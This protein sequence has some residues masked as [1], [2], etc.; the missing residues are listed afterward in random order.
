MRKHLQKTI[1]EARRITPLRTIA[2]FKTA[3][4]D[5]V[6][7]NPNKYFAQVFQAL[8]IEVNVEMGALKALLEQVPDVLNEGGRSII[9]AA[10]NNTR[11]KTK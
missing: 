6:K 10:P 7:G 1:V 9:V 2:E 8:R 3:V 11:E 5:V 4:H